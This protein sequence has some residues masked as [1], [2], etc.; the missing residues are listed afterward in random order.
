M[1]NVRYRGRFYA[2][3]GV[4]HGH[5]FS[6]FLVPLVAGGFGRL[7]DCASECGSIEG[8]EIIIIH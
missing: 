5:H 6:L 8:F 1:V 7:T 2:N 3:R 4:K